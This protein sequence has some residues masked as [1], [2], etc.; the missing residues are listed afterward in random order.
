MEYEI[1]DKIVARA[2]RC[3]TDAACLRGPEKMCAV[4]SV[5]RGNGV[6]VTERKRLGCP[7]S[8]TFGDGI[9]C[10]CPVRAEMWRKHEL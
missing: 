2:I 6:F 4:Q 3:T 1:S 5:I 9:I 10:T 8:V 7:Y